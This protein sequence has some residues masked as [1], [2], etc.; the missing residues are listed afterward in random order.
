MGRVAKVGR[1]KM[2]QLLKSQAP[3]PFSGAKILV[4]LE[5]GH[6]IEID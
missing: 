6:K 5:I 4:I 1:P 2:T 3:W